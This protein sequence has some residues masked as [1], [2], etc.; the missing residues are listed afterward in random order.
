MSNA[1]LSRPA[2]TAA[3]ASR[4]PRLRGLTW[5]MWRQNRPAF[6]IG[7]AVVVAVAGYA[8]IQHNNIADAV[9]DQHLADCRATVVVTDMAPE[10]ASR[11][12]AFGQKYQYPMRLP[13]Q[14]MLV[15]PLIAGL[16]L[17]APLMSQELES[18][19][20]RMVCTQS[21]TRL[22][23]FAVKLGV[24]VVMTVVITG[25][26]AA[27]MTWWWQPAS[28]LGDRFPWYGWYPF[29]GIGPVVVGQSVLLLLVGVT[30]GLVL[31]RTVLAMGATLAAGAVVMYLLEQVRG[32][33]LP[34]VTVTAQHT[35]ASP[36]P[37]RFWAVS[38]GFLSSSGQR[39]SDVKACFTATGGSYEKCV[40]AHGRTGTWT[41]GHP[42]SQLWGIQW[43]EF[44]LCAVLAAVLAGVCVWWVR[45]RMV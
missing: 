32:H 11:L 23:W 20:Y 1:V 9:V 38:T 39:M 34:M 37:D 7:L 3:S 30:L 8:A 17:G 21:V 19:T 24:P 2:G 14:L 13:L 4:R 22:R 15:V 42:A 41:D 35:T 40:F 36:S 12:L 31:R 44:G 5:L 16:F 6:W 26:L 28:V 45:R 29:D 43:A 27:A 33:L 25:I 10:C 18:K